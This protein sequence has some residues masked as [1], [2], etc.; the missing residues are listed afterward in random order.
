MDYSVSSTWWEACADV[1]V[2]RLHVGYSV[3]KE[4]KQ[5]CT[6]RRR[7]MKRVH[8]V[9]H[10]FLEHPVC[11]LLTECFPNAAHLTIVSSVQTD[12]RW[13]I[14]SSQ[15]MVTALIGIKLRRLWRNHKTLRVVDARGNGLQVQKNC[16]PNLVTP[17]TTL[18]VETS[19]PLYA[20]LNPF[21]IWRPLCVWSNTT[22]GEVVWHCML[23]SPLGVFAER[24]DVGVLDVSTGSTQFFVY[25][26]DRADV[27]GSCNV[28][29]LCRTC[30]W[31][32]VTMIDLAI[33]EEQDEKGVR[34]LMFVNSS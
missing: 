8:L 14:R 1:D 33:K 27:M 30:E 9:M 10:V 31:A 3:S 24:F 19:F 28:D 16:L 5:L 2:E 25:N 17:S 13:K 34:R 7:H 12:D 11:N 6:L 18:L 32:E 15:E 22:L 4:W 23:V 20:C 26:V 29:E 21:W